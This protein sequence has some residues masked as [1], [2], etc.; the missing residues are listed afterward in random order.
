MTLMVIYDLQGAV[1]QQ[2]HI[3]C[4]NAGC[5]LERLT[6]RATEGRESFSALAS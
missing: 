3:K 1:L 6:K 4:G 2:G 5:S